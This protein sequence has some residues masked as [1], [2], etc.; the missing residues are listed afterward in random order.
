MLNIL[1]RPLENITNLQLD[2]NSL[3]VLSP[4]TLLC[5]SENLRELHLHHNQIATLPDL[6]TLIPNLTMLDLS[7]NNL[8]EFPT[9]ALSHLRSLTHLNLGCNHI[10]DLPPECVATLR[11]LKALKQLLLH[12]NHL[13]VNRRGDERM[14]L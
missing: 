11:G 6:A 13:M 9:K 4:D 7:S 8:G 1:F 10:S 2:H 3:I 12:K 5:L 14:K